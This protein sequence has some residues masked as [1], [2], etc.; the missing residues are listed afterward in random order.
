M[1]KKIIA[2][3][4]SVL[5]L[6]SMRLFLGWKDQIIKTLAEESHIIMVTW[7]HLP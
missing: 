6:Y 5:C 1:G 7:L 3:F 4:L 2:M